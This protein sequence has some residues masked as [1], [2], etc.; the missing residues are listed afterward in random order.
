MTLHKTSSITR[1]NNIPSIP[2]LQSKKSVH[3]KNNIQQSKTGIQ[4]LTDD[5]NNVDDSSGCYVDDTDDDSVACDTLIQENLGETAMWDRATERAFGRCLGPESCHRGSHHK[6]GVE[7][8][9]VQHLSF[10]AW[11]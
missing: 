4:P 1:L 3:T 6:K 11:L 8:Q 7:H 2:S 10:D 5:T 9:G